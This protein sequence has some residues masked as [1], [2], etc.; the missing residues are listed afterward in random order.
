MLSLKENDSQIVQRIND[1]HADPRFKDDIEKLDHLLRTGD[2]PET[3]EAPDDKSEEGKKESSDSKTRQ[4]LEQTRE[5][6]ED[7]IAN[8]EADI[9]LGKA[10]ILTD[11]YLNELPDEYNDDDKRL[12]K[13]LLTDRIDWEAVEDDPELLPEAFAEGFQE[14][15]NHYQTPKGFVPE[16]EENEEEPGKPEVTLESLMEQDWGKLK[17]VTTPDGKTV[18]VPAVS[19]DQ[20]TNVLAEVIRQGRQ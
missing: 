17:E 9:I 10:D 2:F 16:P 8:Q 5:S 14:T 18:K 11:R 3:E 7:R 19:D 4:L 6:L 12:I 15:L 13:E 1:L 20:Y